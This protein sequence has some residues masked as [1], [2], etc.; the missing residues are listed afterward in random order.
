[1]GSCQSVKKERCVDS[2]ADG[3][4]LKHDYVSTVREQWR[5]CLDNP[6]K[7]LDTAASKRSPFKFDRGDAHG[8]VEM[9]LGVSAVA[10]PN[11][12]TDFGQ[13][14][15]AM[16]SEIQ[17]LWTECMPSACRT[18]TTP[19]M[20]IGSVVL[21]KPSPQEYNNAIMSRL[22]LM[23]KVEEE[24]DRMSPPPRARIQTLKINPDGCVTLQLE[25]D[26]SQDVVMTKAELEEALRKVPTCTSDGAL[27]AERR[28]F[29]RREDG[30][31]SVTR[32]QQIRLALGGLGCE[33]KGMYT[34][35]HMVV[36][37][38]TD[39][40]VMAEVPQERLE[41]LWSMSHEAF[42]RLQGEWFELKRVVC[43]VYVER[44]LNE[45]SV[46]LAP[47]PGQLPKAFPETSETAQ[48]LL[49]GIFTATLTGDVLIDLASFE[50]RRK[51]RCEGEWLSFSGEL[52]KTSSGLHGASPNSARSK[53]EEEM[54]ELFQLFDKDNSGY[55][56]ASELGQVMEQLGEPCSAQEIEEMLQYADVDGSGQISF[57]EFRKLMRGNQTAP[58]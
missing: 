29:Q 58:S 25:H 40:Q 54:R 27:E 28:K 51:R 31:Y 15:M 44:S 8:H 13:Q 22:G 9:D 21:D 33:I 39:P 5:A 56:N 32:F 53:P 36:V 48:S 37:N 45:G 38:L 17:M 12:D 52:R 19:H 18:Q 35:G 20:S 42:T 57:E 3:S 2:T 26:P 14:Y 7:L 41:A 43:L 16:I 49:G 23:R 46:V 30:S 1:M 10:L 6:D 47:T 24:M 50:A 55:V 4:A 34:A 11:P